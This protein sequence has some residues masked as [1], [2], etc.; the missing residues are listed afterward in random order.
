[1]RRVCVPRVAALRHAVNRALARMLLTNR[2][3]RSM[4]PLRHIAAI[5]DGMAARVV[6]RTRAKV[7]AEADALATFGIQIGRWGNS[8]PPNFGSLFA[9]P[10]AAVGLRIVW[11]GAQARGVERRVEAARG[12]NHRHQQADRKSK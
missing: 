3:T 9:S 5:H 2:P 11:P 7:L 10:A 6:R 12:E 8:L 4:T 1:M